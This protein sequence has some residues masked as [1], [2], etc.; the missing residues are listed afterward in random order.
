MA[1]VRAFSIATVA[2]AVCARD[3]RRR[4][5]ADRVFARIGAAVLK[6]LASPEAQAARRDVDR[7]SDR[8]AQPTPNSSGSS[9]GVPAVAAQQQA[10]D[11]P[12]TGAAP[13]PPAP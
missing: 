10:S 7:R 9:A 3:F 12:I 13:P 2:L 4:A 6:S 1:A 5:D 8:M 11:L